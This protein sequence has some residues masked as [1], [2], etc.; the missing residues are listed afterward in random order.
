MCLIEQGANDCNLSFL[1]GNYESI[2]N[3][4][5]LFSKLSMGVYAVYG[6][7]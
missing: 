7:I 5:A 1:R 2:M 6:L 4:I 3:W